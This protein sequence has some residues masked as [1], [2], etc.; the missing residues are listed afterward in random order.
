MIKFKNI[1]KHFA[2]GTKAV[3][4]FN[5]KIN[6]GEL[7]VLIGP[8]G[9]GKTTTLKMINRLIEPTNGQIFI[10]GKDIRDWNT[11]ALR[12]NTGYVL[13]Q[14]A[15]FP[16]MTIEENVSV[17]PDMK[18]WGKQKTKKRVDELLDMVSLDPSLYKNRKPT[19]LSGGQQQRVGVVRALAADPDILLMDEPFSALDPLTREQLQ[20]DI[21]KLQTDIQKTIV[22][23]THDI[24]EAFALG[25][26]ICLMNEG[27][28]VQAGTPRELTRQPA[29]TFVKE[30][31][32]DKKNEWETPV[33]EIM[34]PHSEFIASLDSL[35]ELPLYT[36]P[37]YIFGANHQFLGRR[38][39]KEIVDHDISISPETMLQEAVYDFEKTDADALPVIKEGKLIGVLSYKDIVRYL[40][41]VNG[42]LERESM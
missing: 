5:L 38:Q 13:Q 17:V 33:S 27:K 25:D 26:R 3:H 21:R 29:N 23:V 16:T 10:E 32:G 35:N 4:E 8:S 22:F 7:F 41:D 36:A 1:T 6:Q 42:P 30:F 28:I 2:D 15:L 20:K 37:L 24:D 39:G 18:K 14:I 19:E 11:Q 12:W 31:I 34:D 9:C 40:K